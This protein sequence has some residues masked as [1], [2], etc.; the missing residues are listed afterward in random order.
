MFLHL[1]LSIAL[2]QDATPLDADKVIGPLVADQEVVVE[3][4]PSFKFKVAGKYWL[5]RDD[6]LRTAVSNARIIPTLDTALDGCRTQA[7]ECGT[8]ASEAWSTMRKQFEADDAT[9]DRYMTEHAQAVADLAVAR[10]D[11]DRFRHQRTTAY[12]ILGGVVAAVVVG[13][14]TGLS[15]AR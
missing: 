7:L 11:G 9:L 12:L 10:A 14:S 13:M 3:G 8:A 1:L 2:A 5:I 6:A 15:L 4:K